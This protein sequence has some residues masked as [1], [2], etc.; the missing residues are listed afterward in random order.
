[1]LN[2]IGEVNVTGVKDQLDQRVVTESSQKEVDLELEHT[3]RLAFRCLEM[4]Q[5]RA[6][7]DRIS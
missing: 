3:I 1:M 6:E 7:A 5:M 2:A 4:R